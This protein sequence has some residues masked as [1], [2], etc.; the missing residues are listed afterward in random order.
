MF[1]NYVIESSSSK[2]NLF[3]LDQDLDLE[4]PVEEEMLD[5]EPAEDIE[6]GTRANCL[7]RRQLTN[8]RL[9]YIVLTPPLM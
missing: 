4:E 7:R 9:V 5:D 1:T 6:R 2:I 8:Q 3:I